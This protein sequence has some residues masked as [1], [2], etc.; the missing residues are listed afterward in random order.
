VLLWEGSGD[1]G[2]VVRAN[3][4]LVVHPTRLQLE[5]GEWVDIFLRR[6]KL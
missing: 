6:G 1:I 2:S 5:S 3:C 4:F